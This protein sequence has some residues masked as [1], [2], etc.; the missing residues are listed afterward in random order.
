M[1]LALIGSRE[2]NNYEQF[3]TIISKTLDKW[4][5]KITDVSLVVSG[6][7]KGADSLA[8]L[9]ATENKKVMKI[10]L[11]DWKKFGK[12][13]GIIRNKDIIDECTHVIAFPSKKG[14]GTQN[15]IKRAKEANKI[16]EVYFID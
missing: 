6:G 5:V 13:A 4:N 8:D 16:M 15:S 7:A 1:I 10:F 11:P 2:Y 14:K 12:A 9:W 3:K